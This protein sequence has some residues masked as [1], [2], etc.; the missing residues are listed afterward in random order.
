M[1]I[2]TTSSSRVGYPPVTNRTTQRETPIT[3][4]E[5]VQLSPAV[6]TFLGARRAVAALPPVRQEQ[7]DLYQGLL[8]SGRY[9]VNEKACAKAMVASVPLG[10]EEV[11]LSA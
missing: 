4:R 8:S 2:D 10:D 7:V 6:Q 3:V 1:R 11:R 5:A 9:Q